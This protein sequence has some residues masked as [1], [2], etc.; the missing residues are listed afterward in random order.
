MSDTPESD[1]EALSKAIVEAIMSSGDVKEALDKLQK[2][3][4]GNINSIMVF[5]VRLDSLAHGNEK[6]KKIEPLIEEPLRLKP[7]KRRGRKSQEKPSIVDGKIITKN[8][9]KFMDY[10]SLNFDQ[11]AWLKKNKLKLD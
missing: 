5:M 11:I 1:M 4:A 2:L 9:Q 7:K 8:E 6:G 10:L 3:D